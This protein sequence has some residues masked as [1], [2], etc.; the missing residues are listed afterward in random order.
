MK[1]EL[2]QWL[3]HPLDAAP[4]LLIT[5]LVGVAL[6]LLGLVVRPSSATA[7]DTM[8]LLLFSS[9]AVLVSIGFAG[10][11]VIAGKWAYIL[12]FVPG[13]LIGRH[14]V[15][16]RIVRRQGILQRE[17]SEQEQPP[18]MSTE[19]WKRFAPILERARRAG[20]REFSTDA[21]AIRYGLPA[22][23]TLAICIGAF[24]LLRQESTAINYLLPVD[25][26]WRGTMLRGARFGAAGAY[27]Y[28][29]IYL[30]R[31]SV[32]RDVTSGAALWSAVTLALGP[33]MGAIVAV[34]W[35]PSGT[36]SSGWATDTLFFVAGISPRQASTI[37]EEA[38]RRLWLPREGSPSAA[39]RLGPLT[40]IRG[41]D[42]DTVERL[43][44]EGIT[45]AHSLAMADPLK[46][47]RNTNFDMRLILSWID[48]AHL[49]MKLPDTW[50]DLQNVGISGAIDLATYG[51]KQDADLNDLAGIAKITPSQLRDLV[52]RMYKDAQITLIWALY[53]FDEDGSGEDVSQSAPRASLRQPAA[54][55]AA[56]AGGLQVVG[57]CVAA[58]GL[59]I[60]AACT[61]DT[62]LP[63]APLVGMAGAVAIGALTF[64]LRNN[65]S[66]DVGKRWGWKGWSAFA[67][68]MLTAAGLVVV[69][70]RLDSAGSGHEISLGSLFA[71]GSAVLTGIAV[72]QQSESSWNGWMKSQSAK[73]D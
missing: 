32:K 29:L 31:R 41:I 20:E 49:F 46:L 57:L 40:Q 48:E 58:A 34:L 13:I 68:S 70:Y 66:R 37:V 67:G 7:R 39:P 1:N 56:R 22:L 43:E 38:A 19:E 12:A 55:D 65:L 45:D 44:E 2:L 4:A 61:W 6:M 71:L 23:L 72:A 60:M 35:N 26:P 52:D 5:V 62:R 50:I 25:H 21:I 73:K 24:E 10:R 30:G 16:L 33:I 15:F 54:P 28:G 69:G 42:G 14:A 47:Y 17:I 59:A 63:W 51:A 11:L 18:G 8:S 53:Q 27:I 64:L 9:G 3:A 36:A